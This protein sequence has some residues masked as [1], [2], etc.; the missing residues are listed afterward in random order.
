MKYSV[1]VESGLFQ[2]FE[3]EA[4]GLEEAKQTAMDLFDEKKAIWN[5]NV[6][7]SQAYEIEGEMK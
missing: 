1:T 2:T 4:S 6:E 7:V 5:A 3:I